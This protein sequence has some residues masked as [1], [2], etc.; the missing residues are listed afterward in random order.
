MIQQLSAS[1]VELIPPHGGTLIDLV[2]Q[3]EEKRYNFLEKNKGITKI[4][5]K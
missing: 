1:E 5:I 2:I 4:G 3:D